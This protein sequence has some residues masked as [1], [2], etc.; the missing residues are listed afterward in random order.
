MNSRTSTITVTF[1]RPFK[2]KGV[3]RELPP[4]DYPVTTDEELI[5]GLSFPVYRRMSTTIMVPVD[6]S[7]L[8]IE[9]VQ[10]DPGDLQAARE[11]DAAA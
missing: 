5:E 2:L 4:G 9:M 6:Q 1:K 11:R 10:I 3:D 8:S 7:P